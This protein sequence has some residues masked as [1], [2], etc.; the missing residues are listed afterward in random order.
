MP[1]DVAVVDA[2]VLADQSRYF[3][4]RGADGGRGGA[5]SVVTRAGVRA[6]LAVAGRTTGGPAIL[7]LDAAEPLGQVR[8]DITEEKLPLFRCV[9][10]DS[11]L[12][13]VVFA[14][15]RREAKLV[16]TNRGITPCTR[17][18]GSSG[19]KD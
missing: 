17:Y 11:V 6:S 8:V 19:A 2:E 4:G 7:S 13:G 10:S 12:L 18:S 1:G 9:Q 3:E 5:S 14:E 16:E 15:S